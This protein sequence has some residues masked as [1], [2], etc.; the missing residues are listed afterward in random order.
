M[1]FCWTQHCRQSSL[2]QTVITLSIDRPKEE[3]DVHVI[4]T[5]LNKGY[6]VRVLFF[7]FRHFTFYVP[8]QLIEPSNAGNGRGF[9]FG[10][11]LHQHP[12]IE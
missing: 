5:R 7:T 2:Q 6:S 3:R 10:V 12:D 8:L 11:A 9:L 1:Y 4:V